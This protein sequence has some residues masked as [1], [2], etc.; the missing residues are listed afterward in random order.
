MYAPIRTFTIEIVARPDF[1]RHFG[2]VLTRATTS[3]AHVQILCHWQCARERLGPYVVQWRHRPFSVEVAEGTDF[4]CVFGCERELQNIRHAHIQ[5][6]CHWQ[7]QYTRDRHRPY[8]VYWLHPALSIK[9]RV[10]TAFL[11]VFGTERFRADRLRVVV[12]RR[13]NCGAHVQNAWQ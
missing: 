4:V 1:V 12:K 6:P 13:I 5:T 7:W 3:R 10:C 9:M 11:C 2:S 8:I